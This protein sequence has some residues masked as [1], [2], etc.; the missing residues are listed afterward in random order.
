MAGNYRKATSFI[1]NKSG[2]IK[3][4][5]DCW[6][7]RLLNVSDVRA[8]SHTRYDV[9]SCFN[10]EI[11]LYDVE[12]DILD[13]DLDRNDVVT[14]GDEAAWLLMTNLGFPT[15]CTQDEN[16]NMHNNINR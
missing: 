14:I 8:V 7:P 4:N 16:Y 6:E 15:E 9:D 5:N 11:E 1:A 2:E 3:V 12:D 10:N 13:D